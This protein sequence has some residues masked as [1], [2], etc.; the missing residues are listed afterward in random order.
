M[1][2]HFLTPHIPQIEHPV[3]QSSELMIPAYLAQIGKF[4]ERF[5][6]N[7]VI[8]IDE[9]AL[10]YVERRRNGIGRKERKGYW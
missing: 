2:Q 4:C 8:N 5:G 6:P 7:S 10:L 1:H 3:A 9:T